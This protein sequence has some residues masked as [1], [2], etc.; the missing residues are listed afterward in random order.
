MRLEMLNTLMFV[1]D[2]LKLFFLIL[3][4]KEILFKLTI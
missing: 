4:A 3:E 2:I 1:F